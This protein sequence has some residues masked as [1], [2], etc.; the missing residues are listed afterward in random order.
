M[1]F[2]PPSSLLFRTAWISS[3]TSSVILL[4]PC[5]YVCMYVCMRVCKYTG[6]PRRNVPHFGRLFLILKNTDIT[7]TSMSKM[8]SLRRKWP[9]KMRSFCGY[10]HC[11]CRLTIVTPS[12]LSVVPYDAI[13]ADGG[14]WT[15]LH[16]K[17]AACTAYAV[18]L[19]AA[20]RMVGR[21]DVRCY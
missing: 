8:E 3:I 17:C 2:D 14:Q 1:H 12:A 5:M 13:S 15:S 18:Q 9:E 16:K 7:K 20:L 6:C 21:L 19:N 4:C 10:T 11:T